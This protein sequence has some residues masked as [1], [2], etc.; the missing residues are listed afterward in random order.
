MRGSG[1]KRSRG[2]AAARSGAVAIA[3]RAGFVLALASC[4]SACAAPAASRR[5]A[6]PAWGAQCEA[7]GTAALRDYGCRAGFARVAGALTAAQCAELGGTMGPYSRLSAIEGRA[8][9]HLPAPDAGMACS[10]DARCVAGCF[11]PREVEQGQAAEGR[12]GETWGAPV[13]CVNRVKD[14]RAE[15][16]IC[17]D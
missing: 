17:F 7:L 8:R 4:C 5:A 11:A 13:G 2:G 16:T 15:G 9:C 1:T 12:C 6:V 3:R 10:D 14:G